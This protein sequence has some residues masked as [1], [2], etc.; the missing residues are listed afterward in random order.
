MERLHRHHR[1]I[2]DTDLDVFRLSSF[3][4]Y[5]QKQLGP[6]KATGKES[7]NLTW[8]FYQLVSVSDTASVSVSCY[9]SPG[10]SE[11]PRRS[12]AQDDI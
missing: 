9:V 4:C 6:I 5:S 12:L 1:H 3:V 2:S 7:C 10:V 8:S 11:S